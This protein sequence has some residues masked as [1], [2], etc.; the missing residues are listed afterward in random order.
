[1]LAQLCAFTGP[2]SIKH[3][4]YVDSMT[5]CVRLCIDKNLVTV[6]R[7]KKPVAGDRPPPKIVKNPYSQ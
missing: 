7:D 6:L 4:D 2:G 5:Q 1:M 3:D